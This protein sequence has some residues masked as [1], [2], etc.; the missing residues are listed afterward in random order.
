MDKMMERRKMIVCMEYIARQINDEEVFIGWLMGGVADG[1]IPYGCLDFSTDNID[2]YID[3]ETFKDIMSC[4]LRRM[5]EAWNSGGLY[6][7]GVV[8]EDKSDMEEVDNDG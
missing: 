5:V 1:D 4:F 7:G 3:N 8:S 6:C 2:Y